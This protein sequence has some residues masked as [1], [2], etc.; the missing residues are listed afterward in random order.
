[1]QLRR[2]AELVDAALRALD[3][4]PVKETRQSGAVAR[5][6][7]LVPADL[8]RILERL[9]QDGGIAPRDHPCA[10]AFERLE[11][12]RHRP[13]RI[14]HHGLAGKVGQ[15]CLEIAS[16]VQPDTIAEMLADVVTHLLG[17]DE[18]VGGAVGM[19]Q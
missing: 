19:D 11:D 16:L 1:M 2:R 10:R 15:A 8:D 12:R 9:G 3:R 13:L 6:R 14:H 18:Q 17:R 7:G 4:Q 5:L